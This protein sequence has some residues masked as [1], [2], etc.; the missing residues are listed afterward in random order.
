MKATINQ[1]KISKALNI[2]TKA[3]NNNNTLPILNNIL[4]ETTEKG[5]KFSATNLEI[6]ISYISTGSI[7]EQG[8]ITIPAKLLTSYVSLLH[9]TD[10]E[11]STDEK[12][13]LHIQSDT[14]KTEIKGLQPEDYPTIPTIEEQDTFKMK[15]KDLL[16]AINQTV[17]ASSINNTRPI[18]SG[19]FIKIHQNQVT[20][21]AT[22]SYRLAE[23]KVSINESSSEEISCIVPGKTLQE[24]SKILPLFNEEQEVSISLNKNQIAFQLDELL[25]VSRLIEGNFPNYQAIIPE[26]ANTTMITDASELN[27]ALKRINLF[28]RE[29]N[30]SIH[31]EGNKETKKLNISTDETKIGAEVTEL[32]I[33]IQGENNRISLNSQYLLDVLN[34]HSNGALILKVVEKN[35]PIKVVTEKDDNFVYII[36]PLK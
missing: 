31:L 29:I 9:N 6:A 10:L 4:I 16:Q 34:I 2:V 3:I 5:L 19:V 15:I 33:D 11:L 18:L 17:F 7:T 30:N 23:K 20:F 25:V 21:A 8:S 12:L 27:L 24:L 32:D 14:S 22:D 13:H 1:Q 35:K 28:A 26:E 36:M